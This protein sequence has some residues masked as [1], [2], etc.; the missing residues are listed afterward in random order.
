MPYDPYILDESGAT[1]TD[2]AGNPLLVEI[3]PAQ[4]GDCL[5]DENGIYILDENAHPI[6]DGT[7]ILFP[8]NFDASFSCDDPIQVLAFSPGQGT[9]RFSCAN[10]SLV[11]AFCPVGFDSAVVGASPILRQEGT[12]YLDSFEAWFS[13]SSPIQVQIF[14]PTGDMPGATFGD[15]A[16][17]DI[18]PVNHFDSPFYASSPWQTLVCIPDPLRTSFQS[19]NPARTEDFQSDSFQC[20]FSASPPAQ[21]QVITPAGFSLL[22]AATPPSSTWITF[23]SGFDSKITSG[24]LRFISFLMKVWSIKYAFV[25]EGI[26]EIVYGNGVSGQCDMMWG[27]RQPIDGECVMPWGR[28]SPVGRE[29]QISWDILGYTPIAG[30]SVMIWDLIPDRSPIILSGVITGIHQG[31]QI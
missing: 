3:P 27:I 1:I 25:T 31:L 28:A 15:P 2:E 9:S 11:L 14:F 24:N 21:T 8:S 18:F 26:C 10:L 23:P 6:T 17:F 29:Y 19:S 4:T 5:L 22:W 13:S 7:Q 16:R 12:S 30:H 20:L